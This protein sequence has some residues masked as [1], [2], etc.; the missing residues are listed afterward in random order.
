MNKSL[1]KK[2]SSTILILLSLVCLTA[3]L[4]EASAQ[5][6]HQARLEYP[7]FSDFPVLRTYLDVV[8]G[9]GTFLTGLEEDNIRLIEDGQPRQL[10]EF[11]ELTPGIQLVLAVNIAPPFAI[12]DVTGNSRWEYLNEAL[13]IWSRQA[14]LN[15]GD[16]LSIITND[17]LERTHLRERSLFSSALNRYH[18]QPRNTPSNLNVLAR[19]IEIASDPIPEQGMKRIVLLLTPPPSPEDIAA[20]ENLTSLAVESNVQVHPWLVSSPAFLD[21]VGANQ[22]KALARETGGEFFSFTGTETIPDL[23]SLFQT[24]RGTYLIEYHTAVK[25]SGSHSVEAVIET[26][27]QKITANL[28]FSLSILPPNPI[29]VSPPRRISRENPRPE[30]DEYPQDAYQ[31]EI[32]PLEVIIEFPDDLPRPLAKTVLRVD[33]EIADSNLK[34]PFTTFTWDLTQYTRDGTHYLTV[35]AQDTLGITGASMRTPIQVRVDQ[36]EFQLSNLFGRNPLPFLAL[37]AVI[38][39][40]GV[41]YLLIT[42][43]VIRPREMI[44]RNRD[45]V[46]PKNPSHRTDRPQDLS[47]P[48][49]PGIPGSPEQA[50]T[51]YAY[52]IP[53]GKPATE[54]F[55]TY[56]PLR[57]REITFGSEPSSAI[58][59]I[60]DPSVADFHARMTAVSEESFQLQDEGS[61]TGTWINYNQLNAHHP[62]Q[63]KT[64]DLIHIGRVGFQVESKAPVQGHHQESF[65]EHQA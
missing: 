3:G 16:D 63:V 54:I 33:G 38:L 49:Q 48:G 41:L 43:G 22:L 50:K 37:F 23:E 6:E 65:K 26:N 8:S 21:S 17:G 24:L 7:D 62:G 39:G 14:S 28:E 10:L 45:A 1:L 19:A 55:D 58:I 64:G 52:L 59:T 31:P 51:P 35:E 46:F 57:E 44:G 4:P 36:P 25:S 61:I 2:T 60:A 53:E 13:Q 34:P 42:R 30:L 18:P 20:L 15:T 9:N 5:S 40:F 12:Q 32:Y 27:D 11:Q 29:L 56:L 47:R